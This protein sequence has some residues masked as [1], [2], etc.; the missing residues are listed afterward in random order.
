MN[1]YLDELNKEQIK[2]VTTI[3]R[4]LVV[5]AGAGSGKTRTIIH[6][7]AYLIEKDFPPNKILAITFTNK[8]TSEMKERIT[9]MVGDQEEKVN[10]MTYHSLCARILRKEISILGYPLNFNILDNTDQRFILSPLY[11]KFNLSPKTHSY[12]SMISYISNNKTLG[13][14]PDDLIK[15]SIK[16]GDKIISSIYKLYIQQ[17]KKIKALDFDDLIIKVYEIFHQYPEIAKKWS[18][19]FDYIL[20]DEFQD[21]SLMQYKIIKFLSNYKNITIVG[22]PDQ[23]IY[24]WRRAD[25]TLINKFAKDFPKSKII[26]LE[27]NY[28]STKVILDTA[29]RLIQN[30]KNRMKKN[31]I[32][33]KGVGNDIEFHHAS[34]EDA[35]SRW[36]VQKINS[37]RKERNQLKSMAILY[38]ANYLSASIEK[39]LIDKGLNYIVFGGV[40]FFE[41]QE[42]KDVIAF[43][44]IIQSGDEISMRRMI[45]IPSRKIGK[46]ALK[47]IIDF[48]EKHKLSIYD[49]IMQHLNELEISSTIKEQIIIFFNLINKYKKA[50]RTN[51]I[52]LV[53][54]NFLTDIKYYDVW[55]STID[56]FRIDNI[57][58]LINTIKEWEKQNP[59]GSLEDYLNYIS[60][61]LDKRQHFF[62]EDFVSLM[63]I[64]SAKGLEFDNVFIAGFSEGIFPS[65]KA[66][67][68]LGEVALEEERRLAY[69]AITRAKERLYISNARGYSIDHRFQKK[70]SRFLFEMGINARSLTKQFIPS[71]NYEKKNINNRDW[72]EG[73][74][75]SHIKFGVGVILEVLGDVISIEFESPHGEKKLM[76]NHNSIERIL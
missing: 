12:Q 46:A 54:L 52:S 26:K 59:K 38:R 65:K 19:K 3:D 45:N 41:R 5:I 58:E 56:Q 51:S 70:P 42:I 35:E 71:S 8:S 15:D 47:K 33:N 36:I 74:K 14:N 72:Q 75:A 60:L 69:V 37:L 66:M 50:L 32:C 62:G 63:T 1:N 30:N 18:N 27:N 9:A 57:K 25:A 73:D 20:V 64:H 23:T 7:I 67:D 29:N 2:S 40:K 13:I 44:K 43:L 61:Y 49:S 24:S 55:N 22:D 4:P 11:K 28:R 17:L 48:S 39:S 6:K 68:T 10:I 53:I 76:K 16:E 31:L 34:S 21:T